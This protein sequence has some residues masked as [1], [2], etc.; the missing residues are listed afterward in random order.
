LN[1]GEEKK[2]LT[3]K[4][5]ELKEKRRLGVKDPSIFPDLTLLRD[6]RQTESRMRGREALTTGHMGGGWVGGGV[7]VCL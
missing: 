6:V 2:N 5:R 7:F 1:R 3:G 4:S